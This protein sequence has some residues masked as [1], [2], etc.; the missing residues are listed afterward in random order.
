MSGISK[1]MADGVSAAFGG[2]AL[3]KIKHVPEKRICR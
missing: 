1:E 2:R 3:L